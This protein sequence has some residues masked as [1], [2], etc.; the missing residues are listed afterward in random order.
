MADPAQSLVDWINSA[1][2]A[3]VAVELMAIFGPAGRAPELWGFRVSDW[4]DWLFRQYRKR[5]SLFE[6]ERPVNEA[7]LE[8][9]QVLEHAE[10][11][12]LR[13][14]T[15]DSQH[16]YTPARRYWKATTLGLATLADGND[17]VRQRIRDRTGL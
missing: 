8:A 4:S 13:M 15:A 7:I 3:D 16:G 9:I 6:G 5:F 10:L 11:I 2:S 14:I 1:P 12:H 17:A